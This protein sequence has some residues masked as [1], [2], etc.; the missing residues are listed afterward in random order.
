[1]G[2]STVVLNVYFLT[3]NLKLNEHEK[4]HCTSCA[5]PDDRMAVC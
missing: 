5:I 2:F 4:V 3:V 1:M